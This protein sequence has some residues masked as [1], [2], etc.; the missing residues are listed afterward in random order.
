MGASIAKIL[1]GGL[2]VIALYNIVSSPNS[3]G[4]LGT[5]MTGSVGVIRAL[6][7]K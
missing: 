2:V 3:N 5:G 1:M 6:E 7:G 4:I